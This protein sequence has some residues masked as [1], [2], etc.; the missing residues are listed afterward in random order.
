LTLLF[1]IGGQLVPVVCDVLHWPGH[2]AYFNGQNVRC[3]V[4]FTSRKLM[5]A[6]YRTQGTTPGGLPMDVG[7][8]PADVTF[9]PPYSGCRR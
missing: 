2:G 1:L 3:V 4:A 5:S 9:E 8:D 6:E 7:V